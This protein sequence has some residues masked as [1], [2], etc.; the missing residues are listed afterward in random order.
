MKLTAKTVARQRREIQ[1]FLRK[2]NKETID[3]LVDKYPLLIK[4]LKK[5]W[6]VMNA[7]L[8]DE[9]LYDDLEQRIPEDLR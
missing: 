2:R 8:L 3:M 1:K 5:E 9:Y 7:D 6:D 4:A